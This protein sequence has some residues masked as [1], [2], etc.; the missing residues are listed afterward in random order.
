MSGPA[1]VSEAANRHLVD[2][3]HTPLAWLGSGHAVRTTAL[4]AVGEL[5]ADKLPTTPDRTIPPSL[6]LRAISGAVCGYA[7]CGK[8]GSKAD[9]WI[10]AAIG[11]S[12]ALAASWAG[13]EYRKHVKLPKLV[14]AFTEDAFTFAAGAAVIKAIGR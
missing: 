6:V 11:A 5:I 12:A 14:A 2:L 10:S 1:I 8:N 13:L 9:K 7:V 3:D 4:L